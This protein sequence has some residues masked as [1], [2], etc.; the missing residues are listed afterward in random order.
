MEIE[1]AE[2]G[3]AD[4]NGL[5]QHGCKHWLEVAGRATDDLKNLRGSRLLL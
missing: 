3:I 4:A 2:F 5:P 1:G